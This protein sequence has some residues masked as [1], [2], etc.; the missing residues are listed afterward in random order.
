MFA[1]FPCD[2][3]L[4][5]GPRG[6]EEVACGRRATQAAIR[7]PGELAGASGRAG[8][9]LVEE[10]Y[11]KTWL[12]NRLKWR[13]GLQKGPF[14]LNLKLWFIGSFLMIYMR[15]EEVGVGRMST[16]GGAGPEVGMERT[17][18]QRLLP[19]TILF[20]III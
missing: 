17:K 1:A 18:S 14:Y 10:L 16:S 11:G 4:S 8:T 7:A 15:R 19:F 9:C 3:L 12:F 5:G 20:F 13:G 2:L 6:E